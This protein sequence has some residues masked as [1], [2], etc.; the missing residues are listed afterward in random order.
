[1]GFYLEE[2]G[3]FDDFLLEILFINVDDDNA[4]N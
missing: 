1:M 3:T 4:V 2:K